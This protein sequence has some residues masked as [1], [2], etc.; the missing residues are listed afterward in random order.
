MISIIV[1]VYK[2]EKYLDNCI[3]SLLSQTYTDLEIILVD[4]GSPDASGAICDAYAA[5]DSRI[6]VI[7]QQN[8]GLSA[9]RNAGLFVASG[10]YVGFVDADDTVEPDM[11]E[12]L[13]HAIAGHQLAMCGAR[14][15]EEGQMPQPT[16]S[17]AAVTVLDNAGLWEEI[18]GRLNN[19][20]WN[21]LYRADLIKDSRFPQG[22]IH[23]EDLLFHL[24]YLPSVQ[25]GVVL[26][27]VKYNYYIHQGSIT[28]AREF[29]EKVFDE[30]TVKDRAR[31]L[32]AVANPSYNQKA[33]YYSFIARMNVCRKLYRYACANK[34]CECL[35][36]YKAFWKAHYKSVKV[37]L[38]IRRRIEYFLLH[39]AKWLYTILVRRIV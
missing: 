31:E 32:V 39:N 9:A 8:G 23:G 1:P 18:F 6:K 15:V 27:A 16:S 24:T 17:D 36:E 30:V 4:D 33:L 5:K 38:P 25:S 28:K 26:D 3:N 11:Y 2:A 20:A 34:Y 37:R 21:K 12:L 13:M 7:H 22:L 10:E 29:S 35:A 14:R 19:A